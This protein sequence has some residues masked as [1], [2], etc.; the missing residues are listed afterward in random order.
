MLL[1]VNFT[2]KAFGVIL[3][4]ELEIETASISALL[5]LISME[6]CTFNMP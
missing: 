6:T 4:N 3:A 1:S 5:P 2:L